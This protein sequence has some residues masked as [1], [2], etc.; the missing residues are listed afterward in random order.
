MD[1]LMAFGN[2]EIASVV[3]L[4]RNDEWRVIKVPKSRLIP[5]DKFTEK[6]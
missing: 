2:V 3:S 6:S 5:A 1:E 4:P